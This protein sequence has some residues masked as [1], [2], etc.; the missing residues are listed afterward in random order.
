MVIHLELIGCSYE[1]PY[2]GLVEAAIATIYSLVAVIIG[3]MHFDGI[4]FVAIVVDLYG[5]KI[6]LSSR[7]RKDV[8][9]ICFCWM[10]YYTEK[11]A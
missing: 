7:R 4:A 3:Y 6:T 9:Y 11:D 1:I 8:G 2:L 5:N 10:K